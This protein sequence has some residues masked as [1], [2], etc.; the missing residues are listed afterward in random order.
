MQRCICGMVVINTFVDTGAT[1]LE[2]T[3]AVVVM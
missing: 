3:I 2:G 1:G